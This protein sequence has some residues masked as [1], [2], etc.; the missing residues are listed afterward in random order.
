MQSFLT[1]LREATS[2]DDE[3]LGHLTH[4]KDLPHEDPKHPQTAIDLIDQFHKK[5]MG[6]KSSVG[7]SLKTD[8]GA[9]VHVIHDK[10]GIGV[11]DK[12][13]RARGVIARTPKEVDKHFGHQPENEANLKK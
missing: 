3:M 8:G 10:D 6:Q 12:H 2:V 13:R 9:S 4:T 7:A 5:R 11:S 1:F